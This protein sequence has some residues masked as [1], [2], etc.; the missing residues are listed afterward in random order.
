M[1]TA[2]RLRRGGRKKKPFYRIVV[3]DSRRR[4][5]G[6]YLDNIGV[7]QP[8]AQPEVVRI[9]EKKAVEWLSKG[10]RPSKT[11]KSLFTRQG[12]LEKMQKE[13]KKA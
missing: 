1:A 8:V 13:A 12:I 3:I 5:D 4:R 6:V 7:Y 11:V 9:D 10:A 2:I